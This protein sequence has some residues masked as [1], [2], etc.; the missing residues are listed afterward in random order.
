MNKTAVMGKFSK[1]REAGPKLIRVSVL[2][3][4]QLTS[5]RCLACHNYAMLVAHPSSK[6]SEE[7][8]GS[9][10]IYPHIPTCVMR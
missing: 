6:V 2:V 9:V 4:M 10:F 8:L 5:G 3:W 1:A 7:G